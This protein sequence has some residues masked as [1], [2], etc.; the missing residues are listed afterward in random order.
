M[1]TGNRCKAITMFSD[2]NTFRCGQYSCDD[3]ELCYYHSKMKEGKICPT[4]MCS[5]DYQPVFR[6]EKVFRED[7]RVIFRR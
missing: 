2:G 7:G 1:V 5:N 4:D 6:V 3:S